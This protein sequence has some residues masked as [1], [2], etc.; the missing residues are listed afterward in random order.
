MHYK[1]LGKVHQQ[2]PAQETL[3]CNIRSSTCQ[4]QQEYAYLARQC[5]WWLTHGSPEAEDPRAQYSG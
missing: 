3:E 2:V 5:G 1:T 4:T